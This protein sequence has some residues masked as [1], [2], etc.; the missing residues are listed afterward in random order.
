EQHV[1]VAQQDAVVMVI[2]MADF[3][4]YLAV[5]VSFEGHASLEWKAAQKVV[6]RCSPVVEQCSALG[7]I[8]RHARRIRQFA[9]VNNVALKIDEVHCSIFH[10]VRSK[11]SEPRRGAFMI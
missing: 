6:L 2:W 4:Q 3:P 1:A 7:E 11:E 10:K 8:T 9:G 5:P